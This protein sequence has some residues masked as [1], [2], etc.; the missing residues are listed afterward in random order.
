MAR[1]NCV[2]R[3]PIQPRNGNT[4]LTLNAIILLLKELKRKKYPFC[5]QI[6]NVYSAISNAKWQKKK[7]NEN[8]IV[9]RFQSICANLKKLLIKNCSI[10]TVYYKQ[11]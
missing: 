4:K 10:L 11:K 3:T 1:L 5:N 9:H 7:L 6:S 8:R 2:K